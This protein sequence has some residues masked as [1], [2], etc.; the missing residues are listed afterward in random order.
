MNLNSKEMKKITYIALV[1]LMVFSSSGCKKDFL[2]VSDPNNPNSGTFYTTLAN[3]QAGVNGVYNG[4]AQYGIYSGEYYYITNLIP[5]ETTYLHGEA[6]YLQLNN[7]TFAP[8]NDVIKNYYQQLYQVVGRANDALNGIY[9]MINSGSFIGT[10]L[11]QLNYMVGQ[12]L[13]LR[14]LA[15]SYLVR[16]FGEYLPTNPEYTPDKKGVVMI[17]TVVNSRSQLYKGRSTCDEVYQQVIKDFSRAETLLPESWPAQELGK[18]TKASARGYLGEIYMYLS[19]WDKA[20][21]NFEKIIIDPRYKLVDDYNQ[22]FDRLHFNNSES[23][24]EIQFYNL[25]DGTW[26]TYAYR[27]YAADGMS[28]GTQK[29]SD[30]S[31]AQFSSTIKINTSTLSDALAAKGSVTGST[32]KGYIDTLVK[33]SQANLFGNTYNTDADLLTVLQP[34]FSFSFYKTD[35]TYIAAVKAF[36]N[37]VKPK[38]PRLSATAY[39]PGKDSI[40]KVPTGKWYPYSASYAGQKKYIP[41]DVEVDQAKSNGFGNDGSMTMNFRILR[42]DDVYLYYAES[43]YHR[44]HPDVA[45]EYINKVVRRAYGQNGATSSANDYPATANIMDVLKHEKFVEFCLEGKMWYDL[46]RWN[47]AAQE[48]GARG[49]VEGKHNTLPIP[50]VEIQTNPQVLQNNY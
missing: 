4:F 15:Y 50:S 2:D 8:D 25:N 40:Y 46:R 27:L 41:N 9:K 44:N 24:F 43:E 45:I 11:D 3:A 48:W 29:V 26:G 33:Y 1:I 38:D 7:F 5:G 21:A 42:L 28:W 47:L 18:A 13:F 37:A 19:D 30:Y 35:N 34:H 14:G 10:D 32:Q 23:V 20:S 12:C 22:N 16:S 17:D 31:I 49:Y 36:I 6:R 39:L